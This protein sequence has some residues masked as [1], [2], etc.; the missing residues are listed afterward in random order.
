MAW[1]PAGIPANVGTRAAFSL[2]DVE[3]S[4]YPR[5][6][7]N[8]GIKA[9]GGWLEHGP[10]QEP[11][12]DLLIARI[13]EVVLA[14]VQTRGS[15]AD[16]GLARA[17]A[18]HEGRHP[19]VREFLDTAALNYLEFLES[20][21]SQVG[22]LTYIDYSHRRDLAPEVSLKLWAPVYQTQ[23]GS[24]EVHRLRYNEARAEAGHWSTGAAWVVNRQVHAVTVV[25]F[26]LGSGSEAVLQDCAEPEAVRTSMDTTLVPDLRTLYV[27]NHRVPGSHCV[28]CKAVSHC[29]DLIQMDLFDGAVDDTPWVRS[30]SEADLSRY[31]TC[32]ATAL[33]KSL[34]LPTQVAFPESMARGVRIHRWIADR[35]A[36]TIPCADALLVDG[37]GF[38]EDAPYLDAHAANCDRGVSTTL[39]LEETLVGWDAHMA[40]VIFMK[41]DEVLL[42][43]GVL[44][45][46]EIKT[47]ESAAALE[48]DVAWAQFA[49]VTAWWLSVLAGGLTA[50]FGATHAVLELEVLTP[51]GGAVHQL[52]THQDEARFQVAGWRLDTPAHWLA[53]RGFLPNPG[54]QCPRCE[55]LRWCKEGRA[56]VD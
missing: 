28:G 42:R 10:S 7:A 22:P 19:L 48:A 27:A 44:V 31:R 53:D 56:T 43:D 3:A 30:L 37:T 36:G 4:D 39:S 46:R 12:D 1:S 45:L 21:E 34:H 55:F 2:S 15:D 26:G 51:V 54:P 23:D 40:D 52:T 5:C 9:R 49:D 50:H 29:P 11:F 17:R 18:T 25:E 13:K 8:V 20:R 24:R 41:P 16:G 47:S 14:I 38:E 33:A 35:H 32:P 6:P